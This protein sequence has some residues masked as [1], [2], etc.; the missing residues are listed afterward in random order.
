MAVTRD[1]PYDPFN[2][3]VTISPESGGEFRGGFSE[4]SALNTM[5]SYADYREGTEPFNR[6]GKI[7]LMNKAG[8]VA[9]KRGLIS[10]M[11]LWQWMN[12]VRIG[13]IQARATAV[14]QLRSEDSLGVIATWTLLRAIPL[15][16]T[17]SPTLAAKD[18]SEVAME[19]LVLAC[20]ESTFDGLDAML[21]I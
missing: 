3:L 19:M 13:D 6:P 15:K 14:I 7:S 20:E 1:D 2:F 11:D 8:G 9:L 12:Q 4:C 10:A 16:W 5:I 21:F 18:S 17:S